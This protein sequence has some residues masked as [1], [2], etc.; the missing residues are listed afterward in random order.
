MYVM[1]TVAHVAQ[2]LP[3]NH[4]LNVS[5][6]TF[7]RGKITEVLNVVTIKFCFGVTTVVLLY[8]PWF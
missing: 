7:Y 2:I 5:F 3:N 6:M 4:G 8:E 1:L